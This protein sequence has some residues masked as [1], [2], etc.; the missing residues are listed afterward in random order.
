M[1]QLLQSKLQAARNLIAYHRAQL[2]RP[3]ADRSVAKPT[4]FRDVD[5]GSHAFSESYVPEEARWAYVDPTNG[6]ALV[7]NGDGEVLNGAAI[8][9][10]RLAHAGRRA[11]TA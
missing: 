4:A 8:Y 10:A 11:R 2:S 3:A 6:I 1:Y 9:M 5:M 7:T